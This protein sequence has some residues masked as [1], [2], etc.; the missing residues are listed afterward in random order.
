MSNLDPDLELFR[1][2]L[3][4]EKIRLQREAWKA[5]KPVFIIIVVAAFIY[6]FTRCSTASPQD[7]P[8][9]VKFDS[10]AMEQKPLEQKQPVKTEPE[11]SQKP[12]SLPAIQWVLTLRTY[13]A[14]MCNEY[15]EE[16]PTVNQKCVD[17]AMECASK[18]NLEAAG[19]IDA[20][21]GCGKIKE[22]E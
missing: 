13:F 12:A 10:V 6:L 8:I 2:L 4:L 15:V 16:G 22:R 11:P 9:A 17:A 19:N 14:T 3:Q 20:L 1:R 5:L 7:M 18:V 21:V